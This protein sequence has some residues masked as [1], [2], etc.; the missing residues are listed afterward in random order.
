MDPKFIA[1][2]VLW[3]RKPHCWC[4]PGDFIDGELTVRADGCR[5]A[6][7]VDHLEVKVRNT[8]YALIG[9]DTTL[10]SAGVRTVTYVPPPAALTGGASIVAVLG[11]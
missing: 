5:C 3:F 8:S 9:S 2:V 10:N 11:I 1:N 7:G 4:Y 6:A